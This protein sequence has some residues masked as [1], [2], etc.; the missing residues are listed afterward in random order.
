MEKRQSAE[1]AANSIAALATTLC[2]FTFMLYT[3]STIFVN[4]SQRQ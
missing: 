3:T 2:K 4:I 1:Q